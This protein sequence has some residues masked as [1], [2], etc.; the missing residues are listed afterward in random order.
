MDSE[1]DRTG[2][3]NIIKKFNKVVELLVSCISCNC[4]QDLLT[5]WYFDIKWVDLNIYVIIKNNGPNNHVFMFY[6][7]NI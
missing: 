1:F 3:Q 2:F 7:T 4:N 5:I 6:K